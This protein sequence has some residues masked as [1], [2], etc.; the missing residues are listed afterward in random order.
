[1][2]RR[3]GMTPGPSRAY[4]A[5][6]RLH[7]R[8][9]LLRAVVPLA[10]ACTNG[11]G[12]LDVAW[13]P[14]GDV[15]GG[16]PGLAAWLRAAGLAAVLAAAG[17][18]VLA[19]G[20]LVRRTELTTGGVYARVRHPFYLANL[21][22]AVGTFLLAGPLGAAVAAGWLCLAVPVYAATIRGEEEAL[23]RVHPREWAS[24]SLAVRA[25]L[26]GARAADAPRLPVRWAN[27][28]AEREPPRLL[29]FLTGAAAVLALTLPPA[30][31]RALLAA[32]ALAFGVSH[33]LPR[34]SAL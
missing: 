3:L 31:G 14:R 34:R 7:L 24:Y 28:Q 5:V 33:G 10:A 11:A 29:R 30:S 32:A 8:Q 6:E 18:R 2:I 17:L 20:V 25:L 27:L 9:W 4:D 26:P 16:P 13:L 15:L 23:A 19:K 12:L 22:G 1:M 21:A